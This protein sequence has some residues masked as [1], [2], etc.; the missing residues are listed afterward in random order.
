MMIDRTILSQLLG[1]TDGKMSIHQC[2]RIAK[3]LM[4][5]GVE[6]G[7][8]TFELVGPKGRKQCSWLDPYLGFFQVVGV[9]GLVRVVDFEMC[10]NLHVENLDQVAK[11]GGK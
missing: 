7:Q 4:S 5:S 2:E 8:I 6:P 1:D 3:D 9:A 10:H 11:T